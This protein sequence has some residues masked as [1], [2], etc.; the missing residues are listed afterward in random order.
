VCVVVCAT[1]HGIS[2]TSV[3][4]LSFLKL[5]VSVCVVVCVPRT[6]CGISATSVVKPVCVYVCSFHVSERN[7]DRWASGGLH[8][9]ININILGLDEP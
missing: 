2:A 7:F 5:R 3:V 8:G 1:L 9:L 4:Q 6:C